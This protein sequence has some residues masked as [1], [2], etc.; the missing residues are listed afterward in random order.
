MSGP[1]WTA[2]EWRARKTPKPRVGHGCKPCSIRK[3]GGVFRCSACRR[4]RGWCDG[5]GSVD[6]FDPRNSMCS[7]CDV[8]RTCKKCHGL[9]VHGKCCQECA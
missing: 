7:R 9:L 4:Y 2:E 1:E 6:N 5:A 8:A 3:C